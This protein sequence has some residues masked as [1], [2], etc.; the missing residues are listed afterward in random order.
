LAYESTFGNYD[1]Y[2]PFVET[3]VNLLNESGKF[4]YILPNKLFR[5]DYGEELRGLLSAKSLVSSIVD[6]GSNQ[7]FAESATTY[8]ALLFLDSSHEDESTL[9]WGLDNDSDPESLIWRKDSSDWERN[10]FEHDSLS[11]TPWNFH[12]KE[13]QS[14]IE[15]AEQRAFPLEEIT[16]SIG[17]GSSSGCDEVFELHVEES[18]D[19]L[20]YCNSEAAGESV[21][22]EAEVLRKPIHSTDFNKYI[23]EGT[24]DKH[25]IWPYD[26]T[27]ELYSEQE[28]SSRYPKAWEYLQ[29]NRNQLEDRADYSRWYDYSAP[30]NL[31][32]HDEGQLLIPLLA[33]NPSFAPYPEPQSD[34]LLMASGGFGISLD[35]DSDYSPMYV[36]SLI[37]SRLLFFCLRSISNVFRGGY[38]TCTKQYFR[39]LPIR[40]ISFGMNQDGRENELESATELYNSELIEGEFTELLTRIS[41]YQR[42]GMESVVHDILVFLANEMVDLW[43]KKDELNLALL[44][45]IQPY[46]DGSALTDIGTY[47]PPEGVGDTRLT[48]TKEDYKN[49][50]VGTVTCEREDKSTV[51]IHATARY[52][53]EDEDAYETDQWGYTETE[54]M[55]AMRLSDLSETEADLVEAFVTVAVEEAGGF[56]G[57]RET[58]T[59]TNSLVDRLEAITLPDPDDVADDLRRYRQAVER[60]EELDEKIQ[61]TDDLIDEIVY[62]LYGLT[63]EEIEIVEEA[64]GD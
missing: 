28:I 52:K 56:A 12:R 11:E 39:E 30:R 14:V 31:S 59:K 46:S 10:T 42:E 58:A 24:G 38:I 34:Y 26:S 44:D 17:R 5:V 49:I 48:A 55:P 1:L 9:Y 61:R 20:L 7:V 19:G 51:V 18:G 41:E 43:I 63:D 13:L 29:E 54:P 64:V 22:I 32:I 2:V 25:L 36:L 62:D 37:N 33:D 6:F 50:R 15:T 23:F 45:Y 57:F 47:Q 27:Y 4:G 8:T 16:A 21:P 60:A 40:E 53:P 3:G 35:P